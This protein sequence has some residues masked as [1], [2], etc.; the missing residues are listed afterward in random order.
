MVK[1]NDEEQQSEMQS[2]LTGHRCK[3][4]K[5]MMLYRKGVLIKKDVDKDLGVLI[6]KDVDKDLILM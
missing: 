1:E 3:I 2:N 6:K 5:G 4:L